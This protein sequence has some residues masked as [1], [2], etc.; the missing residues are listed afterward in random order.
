MISEVSRNY[1][2]NMISRLNDEQCTKCGR[3][4]GLSLFPAPISDPQLD[5]EPIL[6][7]MSESKE[8]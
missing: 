7:S 4:L 6:S 8:K 5:S 3:F 2:S 1:L